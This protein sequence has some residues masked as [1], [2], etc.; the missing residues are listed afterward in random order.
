MTPADRLAEAIYLRLCTQW[1][2]NPHPPGDHWRKDFGKDA[3]PELAVWQNDGF[4]LW[5]GMGYEWHT[6]MPRKQVRSLALFILW[7]DV[8]LW[9][10][11]RRA[12]WYWALRRKVR[13]YKTVKP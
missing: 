7:S 6:H 8:R 2:G 4:E 3:Y 11:L 10:G 12:L 1:G 9:F 5:I 13:K